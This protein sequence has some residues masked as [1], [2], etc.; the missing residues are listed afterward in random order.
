MKRIFCYSVLTLSLLFLIIACVDENH[1]G[2]SD[3]NDIRY[4]T[5]QNQSG[6]SEIN[7]ETKEIKIT[8]DT[9]ADVTKLAIDSL[10]LSTFATLSP[11]KETVRDFTSPQT[12]T[13]TAENGNKAIYTV[14]VTQEG[15]NP[16]LE[17][18]A[19]DDWYTPSGKAYKQPGLNDN[20]IWATANDGTTTTSAANV[21]TY[22][23][24][25]TG[26]DYVAQIIT[27]DLGSVSGIVGQR[28][29]SGTLFT[30]KFVLNVSNPPAST[31]FGIPFTAKPKSF[32]AEIKYTAGTPYQD[33][34]GKVM[35]KTDQADIYV[36]LENRDNP[37]AI[38][39][40]ATGW[41]RTGTTTGINLQNIS[42]NLTY[43]TLDSSYPDYQKPGNGLY[44]SATDKPTHII[45]VFASS[46][47]GILYEGGVNSTL[48]VNNFKLQY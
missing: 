23:Y 36:I 29:G 17:N 37:N 5:L 13:V 25:N 21:T 16:Q 34:K 45:V 26:T 40:I 31:Q 39:R 22:P 11:V 38:K 12:Y 20:T 42:V 48:Y 30:G 4:I 18:S 33:G 6:F 1:F 46:A 27:K 24:L 47:D 9:N 10:A 43:G 7:K 41:H 15:S 8:V 19:F 44:G 35:D 32:S 28:M 3:K 14:I 2:A